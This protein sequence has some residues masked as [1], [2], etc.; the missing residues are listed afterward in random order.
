[1]TGR[2]VNGAVDAAGRMHLEF[3][4]VI[5]PA[6]LL[7]VLA[8]VTFKPPASIIMGTSASAQQSGTFDVSAGCSKGSYDGVILSTDLEPDDAIAIA[9]LA[10]RLRGVPLLC[11]VGEASVDKRMMMQEMLASVGLDDG[12]VVEGDG[13]RVQRGQILV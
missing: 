8:A 7:C 9:A 3:R 13:A 1:M 10:P 2:G 4:G 6:A 11:V 12:A 5:I